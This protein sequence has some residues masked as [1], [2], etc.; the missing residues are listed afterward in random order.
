MSKIITAVVLFPLIVYGQSQVSQGKAKEIN[1]DW[2]TLNGTDYSI[3]YPPDWVPDESGL[4]GTTFFLFSPAETE[5][6]KFRANVN[7]LIQDLSK[8]QI[9]LNKYAEISEEQI[10]RMITNSVLMESKRVKTDTDEYH[11]IMYTGEQGSMQLKF[12][13]HYRIKNDKAYV[14]TFTCTQD[15]FAAFKE[16]GES[17]LNSFTCK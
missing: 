14:L 8:L 9:D 15:T 6:T 11:Q 13:Q 1:P 4:M 5:Q 17:I 12:E 16:I 10:K 2:K 7:F 3:S